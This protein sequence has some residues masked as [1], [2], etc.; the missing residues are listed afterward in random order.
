MT[1]WSSTKEVHGPLHVK[2]EL[3]D[4]KEL[5][6]ETKLGRGGSMENVDTWGGGY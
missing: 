6:A 2:S 5:S 4:Y 3:C 1:K